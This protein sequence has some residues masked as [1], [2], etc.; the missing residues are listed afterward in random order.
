M[1]ILLPAVPAVFAVAVKPDCVLVALVAATV[2]F[3]ASSSA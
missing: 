3:L 1:F 2:T